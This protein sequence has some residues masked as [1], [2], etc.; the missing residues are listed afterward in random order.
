MHLDGGDTGS[1]AS[2]AGQAHIIAEASAQRAVMAAAVW[3]GCYPPADSIHEQLA[4]VAV[5]AVHACLRLSRCRS[6]CL[7]LVCCCWLLAVRTW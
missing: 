6:A 4:V 3:C 2:S 7:L 5:L 1:Q